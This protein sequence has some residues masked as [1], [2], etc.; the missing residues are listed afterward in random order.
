MIGTSTTAVITNMAKNRHQVPRVSGSVFLR[1][2]GATRESVA[3]ALSEIAAVLIGSA[4][5]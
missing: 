5:S 1:A 2:A 3:S 4:P